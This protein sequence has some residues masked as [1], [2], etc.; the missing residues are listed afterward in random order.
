MGADV[1]RHLPTVTALGAGVVGGGLG[2]FSLMVMPALGRLPAP[3]AVTAMQRI[4][5]AALTLPFLGVFLGT[6]VASAAVMVQ[7]GLTWPEPYAVAH[8]AG[9]GLYL[10]A[11]L[12]TGFVNVP[13]NDA[14]AF[15]DPTDVAAAQ[16]AWAAFAPRWLVANHVRAV[17]A[18]AAAALMGWR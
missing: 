1:L 2:I 11:I 3:Q 17:A 10:S 12:I 16:D 15:V 5:E 7:A 4:N 18:V 8:L 14:L 13:A 6:A 9:A